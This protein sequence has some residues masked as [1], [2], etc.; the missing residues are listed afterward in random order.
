MIIMTIHM[1]I[2]A[3]ISQSLNLVY[4]KMSGILYAAKTC[5]IRT[6][7]LRI[8][9]ALKRRN[10]TKESVN[11]ASVPRSGALYAAKA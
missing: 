9:P 7:V 3:T 1:T 6:L 8:K 2:M 5:N 4:V 10:V 11:I